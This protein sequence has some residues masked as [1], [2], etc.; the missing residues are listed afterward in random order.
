[1]TLNDYFTLIYLP[2]VKPRIK[3]QTRAD[4]V[5]QW[6]RYIAP[7]LGAIPL[8]EVMPDHCQY[9]VNDASQAGGRTGI[10]V[11]VLLRSVFRAAV[12]SR[13]LNWSPMDAIQRPLYRRCGGRA[14]DQH[15]RA[16]VTASNDVAFNLALHAGLRRSEICRLDWSLLQNGRIQVIDSKTVSGLRVIPISAVLRSVL[17]HP[18]PLTGRIYDG[19]PSSL[20]HRW[21]RFSR[22]QGIK[23]RFHDLRHTY[24]TNLATSGI[25]VSVAQYLAGHASAS[26]TLSIYTHITP[27]GAEEALRAAGFLG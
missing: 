11:F 21:R 5:D 16:I 7:V 1:M 6:A 23:A 2:L 12:A 24:I 20:S 9:V 14:L 26:T 27:D 19:L 8:D 13:R 25:T 4:Y 17:P 22:R 3:D 10:F 15:E 18:L